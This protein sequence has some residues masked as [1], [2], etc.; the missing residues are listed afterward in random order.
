M[1]TFPDDFLSARPGVKNSGQLQ[2]ALERELEVAREALKERLRARERARLENEAVEKE[3]RTLK[4]QHE[5]ELK[6]H[7]RMQEEVAKKKEAREKRRRESG[8]G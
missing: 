2:K 6:I 5:M 1:D 4:D 8:A 3:L 7:N